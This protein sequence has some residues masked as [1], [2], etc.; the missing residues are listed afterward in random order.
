MK[1][2]LIYPLNSR[3]LFLL[4]LLFFAY[5]LH[6]IEPSAQCG[7]KLV[8]WTLLS[9]FC[10]WKESIQ[11]VTVLYDVSFWITRKVFILPLFS[12]LFALATKLGPKFSLFFFSLSYCIFK[13]LYC[14]IP[15]IV[16]K[17]KFVILLIFCSSVYNIF[18]I[19]CFLQLILS[20]L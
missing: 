19:L 3:W 14:L 10:S 1:K 7:I 20:N 12:M 8:V 18:L 4:L 17:E 5:L 9:C 16:S 13:M 11:S 6:P 15:Y 2:V